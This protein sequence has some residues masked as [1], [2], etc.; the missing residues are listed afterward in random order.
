VDDVQ[1]ILIGLAIL[2][3]IIGLLV[4]RS[5]GRRKV[6]QFSEKKSAERKTATSTDWLSQSLLLRTDSTTA[7]TLI[8]DRAKSDLH[9]VEHDHYS[10]RH[11]LDG[12]QVKARLTTVDNAV[13]LSPVWAGDAGGVPQGAVWLEFRSRVAKAASKAGIST[14]DKPTPQFVRLADVAGRPHWA[15]GQN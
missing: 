2:A 10:L 8:D 5:V 3:V 4:L 6:R 9:G 7:K 13:L 15:P 12:E 1:T 14:E 11:P